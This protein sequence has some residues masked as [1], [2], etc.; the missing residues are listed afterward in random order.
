MARLEEH[1]VYAAGIRVRLCEW[2]IVDWLRS[3]P[4]LQART[5]RAGR[6]VPVDEDL[7]DREWAQFM[8]DNPRMYPGFTDIPRD[9]L[10]E[11]VRAWRLEAAEARQGAKK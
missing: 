10:A 1:E 2:E 3:T 5:P 8:L 6:S 7:L 4:A 11:M 9:R